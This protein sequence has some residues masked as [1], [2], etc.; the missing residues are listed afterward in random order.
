MPALKRWNS[1]LWTSARKL[2]SRDKQ[3]R[4]VG[5]LSGKRTNELAH[6][7]RLV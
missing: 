4:W 1:L 2:R 3:L 6:C 5:L 7:T